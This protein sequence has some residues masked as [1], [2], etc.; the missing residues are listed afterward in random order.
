MIH[1]HPK[2]PRTERKPR[3][4]L[5]ARRKR[6]AAQE[7]AKFAHDYG[8]PGYVEWIRSLPSVASGKGPC[9]AAHTKGRGAKLKGHWSTLVPLTRQEHIEELHQH[10][11][12]WFEATYG[13]SLRECAYLL[14]GRWCEERPT[15]NSPQTE[16]SLIVAGGAATEANT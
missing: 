3:K 2:P 16:S 10:G 14:V 6:T 1:P 5:K 8:P 12:P 7:A 13:I 9:E 4:R 11:V 15:L